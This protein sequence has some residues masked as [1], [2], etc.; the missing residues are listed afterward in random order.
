MYPVNQPIMPVIHL[1]E[2]TMSLFSYFSVPL[3]E[4]KADEFLSYAK[5]QARHQ[6]NPP[7]PL[8]LPETPSGILKKNNCFPLI[9]AGQNK[10]VQNLNIMIKGR[11]ENMDYP[12]FYL[13]KNFRSESSGEIDLSFLSDEFPIESR[14]DNPGQSDSV[15]SKIEETC[16]FS[17]CNNFYSPFLSDILSGSDFSGEISGEKPA[18]DRYGYLRVHRFDCTVY[19]FVFY[20]YRFNTVERVSGNIENIS[21]ITSITPNPSQV[22][23]Y[24]QSFIRRALNGNVPSPD[25]DKARYQT[26]IPLI[27]N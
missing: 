2:Q 10:L 26:Y 19:S 16:G 6:E 18:I 13:I 21:L 22:Y 14:D 7:L 27:A 8:F 15:C 25:S 9:Y 4:G 24:I 1:K 17:S 23:G 11:P 12:D 3:S 5:K 20:L